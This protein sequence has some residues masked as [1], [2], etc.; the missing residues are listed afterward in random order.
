MHTDGLHQDLM[1]A[2]RSDFVLAPGQSTS[3]TFAFGYL[4]SGTDLTF[5]NK[6][7][8]P[9]KHEP[10]RHM[11]PL[12]NASSG[13]PCTS[14]GDYCMCWKGKH[15]VCHANPSIRCFTAACGCGDPDPFATSCHSWKGVLPALIQAPMSS[16]AELTREAVWRAAQLQS[17]SVYHEYYKVHSVQQGSAC[18][19]P[20]A[21]YLR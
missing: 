6:Y 18:K 5:L 19:P 14:T 13:C 12:G 21:S 10:Q 8:P 4:P 9:S 15:A 11:A 2:M 17:M 1:A 16:T 20:V 7:R 3:M